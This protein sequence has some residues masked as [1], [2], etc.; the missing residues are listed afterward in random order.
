MA[1]GTQYVKPP[2]FLLKVVL[3]R[4]VDAYFGQIPDPAGHP[5]FRIDPI[6]PALPV[7]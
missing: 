5:V 4:S 6:E 1:S 2:A 7:R 3:G